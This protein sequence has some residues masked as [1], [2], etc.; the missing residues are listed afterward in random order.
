MRILSAIAGLALGLLA[1]APSSQ[2]AT[3]QYD[4]TFSANNF[5]AD[6]FLGGTP[7]ISSVN[8]SFRLTLDPTQGL[9]ES[10]S[11]ITNFTID[12]PGFTD[13]PVISY[14]P[15]FGGSG[16]LGGSANG[17]LFLAFHAV[18]FSA[19]FTLAGQI[20]A[21]TY[22]VL[23]N[24]HWRSYTSLVSATVNVVPTTTTPIPASLVMLLTS[25]GALGGFGYLRNRKNG[26][27]AVPAAA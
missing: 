5:H 26:A 19:V 11:A 8:G 2:A 27:A 16:T 9:F 21:L 15:L 22:E 1:L 12:L 24:G 4:V 7:P 18:D 6:S 17:S 13:T 25:I 3:V 14:T 20:T 23:K 10:T